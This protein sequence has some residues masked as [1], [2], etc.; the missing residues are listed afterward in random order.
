MQATPCGSSNVSVWGY[1]CYHSYCDGCRA[2]QLLVQTG[3]WQCATL[4]CQERQCKSSY[5]DAR[6]VVN[7]LPYIQATAEYVHYIRT[8][9]ASY[10]V[11]VGVHYLVVFVLLVA[12]YYRILKYIKKM[13]LAMGWQ[14]YI[15]CLMVCTDL[16]VIG[17]SVLQ[18]RAVQGLQQ[19]WSN[20]GP[21]LKGAI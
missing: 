8:L 6:G 9:I 21:A 12:I 11:L 3:L 17:I 18:C 15:P 10:G 20:T 7:A 2:M 4:C 5:C 19:L 1:R 14:S 13:Q 16:H